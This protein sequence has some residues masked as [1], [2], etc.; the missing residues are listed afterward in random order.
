[1]PAQPISSRTR[2]PGAIC[3]DGVSS[4]GMKDMEKRC[5]MALKRD[6]EYHS[7]YFKLN[8]KEQQP[9]K[10]LVAGSN[11]AENEKLTF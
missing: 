6:G 3:Q 2:V 4:R 7:E 5:T 11:P 9:Y 8:W 1:M 10:L